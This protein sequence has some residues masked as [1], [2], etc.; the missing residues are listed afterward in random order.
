MR[1]KFQARF[2]KRFT[3]TYKRNYCSPSTKF[4]FLLN[5]NFYN[6]KLVYVLVPTIDALVKALIEVLFCL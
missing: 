4:L 3:T 5:F 1:I 6:Q 2:D